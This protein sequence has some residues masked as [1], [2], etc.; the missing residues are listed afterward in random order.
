MRRKP[1]LGHVWT[2]AKHRRTKRKTL[3]SQHFQSPKGEGI[4]SQM[5]SVSRSLSPSGHLGIIGW[6]LLGGL[7]WGILESGNAP[8]AVETLATQASSSPMPAL[9][10]QSAS[11]PVENF[12]S[13]TSPFGYR[14]DPYGGQRFHYGL[15][16]AAPIGS[17][18]RAWWEG[19]AIKV[20][21][22]TACGTSVVIQSGDWIHIYCHL[23]GYVVVEA[24]GDR[25][26][27]DP[28]GGVQIRQGDAIKSGRRIGRVG[29][30]GR[31]TGPHLHWG[32]KY[33]GNWIDPSLV[34]KAMVAEGP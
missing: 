2:S 23:Q 30:T 1:N 17:Y 25:W 27:V 26:L 4:M 8:P 14:Q 12:V 29:M 7:I 34:L 16:I 10:W 3:Y 9:S 19:E 5:S 13:Y 6:V 32:L 24:D 33:Q 20:S 15:D 28:D 11:F 18:I 31:T 22:D 21:D